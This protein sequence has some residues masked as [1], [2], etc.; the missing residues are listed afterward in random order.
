LLVIYVASLALSAHYCY[1]SVK[2]TAEF[3]GVLYA[4][5]VGSASG[6]GAV[7]MG[8]GGGLE[9]KCTYDLKSM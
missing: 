7:A 2:R 5:C 6:Y 3:C 4:S 9:K 8:S 1:S